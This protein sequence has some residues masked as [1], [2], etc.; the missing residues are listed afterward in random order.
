MSSSIDNY[1]NKIQAL[2][3]QKLSQ[4]IKLTFPCKYM[5]FHQAKSYCKNCDDFV[6]DKCIQ[7]HDKYHKIVNLK[8]I[9]DILIPNITL[10]KDLSNGKFPKEEKPK[11]EGAIETINLDEKIG[12][13]FIEEIDGLINKLICTKKKIVK[14]FDL[15]KNLLKKYNCDENKNIIY[16]EKLMQDILKQEKLEINPL[17]L[18]QVKEIHDLIK[19]EKNNTKVFKEFFSFCN[20][21]EDKNK[22]IIN[23]NKYLAKLRKKDT[24]SIYERINLKTNELNLIMTDSSVHKIKSFLSNEIPLLDNKIEKTQDV[25]KNVVCSYLKIEDGEYLKEMEKTEIEDESKKVVEKIVEVE[26]EK[27]VEKK[28]EVK[29]PIKKLK[30]SE[31]ELMIQTKEKINIISYNEK[32]NLEKKEEN[33]QSEDKDEINEDKNE[34]KENEEIKEDNEEIKENEEDNKEDNEEIK[35][36]EEDNKEEKQNEEEKEEESEEGNEESDNIVPPMVNQTQNNNTNKTSGLRRASAIRTQTQIDSYSASVLSTQNMKDIF[37]GTYN[38][39]KAVLVIRDNKYLMETEEELE[40]TN[41]SCHAKLNNMNLA[42][43]KED[44][45]LNKELSKFS[46]KERNMFELLYPLEDQKIICIY[47]PYVNRVEEI[48]I[49]IGYKFPTN[50]AMYFRLPYCFVSGG[51]ILDEEEEF[52]E[53]NAFYTLRREGPKIFEKMVL[54]EMLEEK[55]N[56]CLFE[57]PYINALCALGGK[58]SKDV[59]VFDLDEKN[60]KAYPQ[61]NYPRENAS[62]CVINETFVYCFFG[63]DGENATYLSS[64]EKFDLVYK[65]EW[66]LINPNGNKTFLKK[67]MCGCVQYKRNFEENIFIVGG[68]NVL[69]NESKDCLVYDEKNN[70]FEKVGEMSLP[71]KS[72]FN[73]CNFITLPNGL[74][75]NF[76]MSSQLIQFEPS[77]KYFFSI[78]NK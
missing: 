70:N 44:F 18:K 33:I 16:D 39:S 62:C 37:S 48:E 47:N 1:L 7:K 49:E 34:I 12:Q 69:N 58:N 40:I 27:I 31:D 9:C 51:N 13:S 10:Y 72:S 57:I 55:S 61:L 24:M 21:L 3:Q 42:K 20:E 28:V 78:R 5:I 29:V 26:K 17:N 64:I 65:S 46:W 6:C 32:N 63:Y 25:F 67:K 2:I 54:P 77:G 30:F 43:A 35:E 73:S 50:C 59:E 76:N 38:E 66:E 75:Y 11:K 8:E 52:E 22:D 41:K 36:N 56:H 74:F 60:W 23:N 71:F 14:F 4:N 68:I 45:D 15:R 19:F 53:T